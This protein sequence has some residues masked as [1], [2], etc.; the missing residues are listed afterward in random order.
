[1][2][3]HQNNLSVTLAEALDKPA[4]WERDLWHSSLAMHIQ[5]RRP[6]YNLDKPIKKTET[7]L[8]L[9]DEWDG[10]LPAVEGLA[11]HCI[12]QSKTKCQLNRQQGNT[13]DEPNAF[14]AHSE[15]KEYWYAFPRP[16]SC[17]VHGNLRY[18]MD[19]VR[20]SS[21]GWILK[22]CLALWCTW[23]YIQ[24]DQRVFVGIFKVSLPRS[25]APTTELQ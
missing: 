16:L 17:W 23:L 6:G 13:A 3:F 25:K 24:I 10:C 7:C 12:L 15:T 22:K 18:T 11:C 14:Y 2:C 8:F 1:M 5:I 4:I 9:I 20:R 21:W 19:D